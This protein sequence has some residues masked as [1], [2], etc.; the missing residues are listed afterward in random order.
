MKIRIAIF[1]A[2][3]AL[4]ASCQKMNIQ[5]TVTPGTEAL[6][7]T[8]APETKT[9]LTEDGTVNWTADDK[10]AVFDNANV[11]NQ[12]IATEVN[13]PLARF[14]GN[15]TEGTTQIYAV[16]PYELAAAANGSTLTVNVPADQTSK[17][18]SFAEEHNISVAQATK[19]A[20][21]TEIPNTTF[22]NVCAL[23]KF[24]IPTYI[25]DA[26]K[27]TISSDKAIAG[28]MTIDYSGKTPV[29]TIAEDGSNKI[30]MTGEFAA[31]STFW[32]VLA[33]VTLNGLKVDV[34]TAQGTYTMSTAAEIQMSAGKYKNLGTLE[35]E[36]AVL[37]SAAAVHIYE[38]DVL[39]GTEIN[40]NLELDE[41]T[42]AYISNINFQIVKRIVEDQSWWEELLNQS[43]AKD[44]VIY[45]YA[46]ASKEA[47]I[48]IP[49]DKDQPYLPAGE[50][51]LKG[52]YMLGN[53]KKDLGE[54]TFTVGAPF[55]NE[56]EPALEVTE[57]NVYTSYTR[58][59]AGDIAGA[60][61]LNGSAIYAEIVKANIS[62]E[63]LAMYGKNAVITFNFEGG[64]SISGDEGYAT[65]SGTE[66]GTYVL[67]S[68]SASFNGSKASTTAEGNTYLISGIPY[69]TDFTE[70]KQAEWIS[71]G[72]TL[73][74]NVK[75]GISLGKYEIG[76]AV[77]HSNSHYG[78]GSSESSGFLVSPRFAVPESTNIKPAIKAF[79]YDTWSGDYTYNIYLGAVATADTKNTSSLS[80]T[81]KTATVNFSGKEL[82]FDNIVINAETPYISISCDT[83]K[84][85]TLQSVSCSIYTTSFVYAE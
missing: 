23:L 47:A 24:T 37:T 8:T 17:A 48:T 29:S 11:K 65:V 36:K 46:T 6:V 20:G 28:N 49:A 60:N 75:V 64:K 25:G 21:Q 62:E 26:T 71:Q 51:V 79:G 44:F 84:P 5:E 76:G 30:S 77:I 66:F 32:F 54:T 16:Y 22:K 13:G 55:T 74:E 3:A 82:S 40:V 58:Y 35:L 81:L 85:S 67:E 14:T 52:T 42:A 33:P 53:V 69:S 56:N 59:A 10:I 18:G 39:T 38:N 80:T 12:F 34:E 19:E 31:G 78:L 68:I 63:I 4:A 57:Y 9:S 2:I 43:S 15:V 1:A 73:N 45:E 72:W 7:I 41:T 83:P 61:A 50:Y 27:V 70:T